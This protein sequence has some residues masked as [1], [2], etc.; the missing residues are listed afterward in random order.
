MS[1]TKGYLIFIINISIVVGNFNLL[2]GALINQVSKKNKLA[3]IIRTLDNSQEILL[4]GKDIKK[5]DVDDAWKSFLQ[6]LDMIRKFL[7]DI[8]G[9]TLNID[10]LDFIASQFGSRFTTNPFEKKSVLSKEQVVEYF[11][12]LQRIW[13]IFLRSMLIEQIIQ[14]PKH[15]NRDF[16]E[17]CLISV[18]AS[19]KDA[20]KTALA[21]NYFSTADKVLSLLGNFFKINP[22]KNPNLNNDLF[23]IFKNASEANLTKKLKDQSSTINVIKK[24]SDLLN[25]FQNDKKI[26]LYRPSVD[27][28]KEKMTNWLR[29]N[30]GEK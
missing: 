18:E 4:A 12:S 3:E 19:L 20:L 15:K 13:E 11:L 17:G 7:R 24:I 1:I 29:E 9:K 30:E 27:S 25:N 22:K 2:N 26:E 6:S 16:Y 14:D 23:I 5:N 8:H 10:D 21:N 28:L